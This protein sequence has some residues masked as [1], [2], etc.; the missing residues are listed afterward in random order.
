MLIS[1]ARFFRIHVRHDLVSHCGDVAAALS[2]RPAPVEVRR[3]ALV[4]GSLAHSG[5]EKHTSHNTWLRVTGGLGAWL[6]EKLTNQFCE[7]N[8]RKGEK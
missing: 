8:H 5:W 3:H 4:L 2:T 6:F 7:G 1:L